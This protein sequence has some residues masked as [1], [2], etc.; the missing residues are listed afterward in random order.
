MVVLPFC[1]L[2]FNELHQDEVRLLI[3]ML[4]FDERDFVIRLVNPF[5]IRV[6][7]RADPFIVL[8]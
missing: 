7:Y 1:G 5:T 4:D 8:R 3:A 2:G 6:E